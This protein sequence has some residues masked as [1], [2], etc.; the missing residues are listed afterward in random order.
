M[1]QNSCHPRWALLGHGLGL[2]A[3][4]GVEGGLAGHQGPLVGAEGL[5]HLGE[6]EGGRARLPASEGPR[7]GL[8]VPGDAAEDVHHRRPVLEPHLHRVEQGPARL[9]LEG[10]G[11]AVPE[12]PPAAAR[13]PHRGGVASALAAPDAHR[14]RPPVGPAAALHDLMARGARHRARRR[15]PGV[16]EELAAQVHADPGQLVGRR[17]GQAAVGEGVRRGER[18]QRQRQQEQVQVH[19]G[20]PVRPDP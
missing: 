19:G 18:G 1:V 15:Q 12:Q 5:Q 6:G 8:P 16:E 3:L 2:A 10:A 4:R 9:L 13:V 14:H 17:G 20:P 7:E 11:A